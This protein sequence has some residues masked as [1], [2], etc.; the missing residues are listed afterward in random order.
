MRHRV[1]R[2]W[3]SMLLII[4]ISCQPAFAAKKSS[5]VKVKVTLVSVELVENNHVG[6]EWATEAT[7]NG[8][9]LEDG[10]SEKFTLKAGGT[11]KLKAVAEEQDKIP[12][13]GKSEKSIKA[14]SISGAKKYEL[15]VKVVENRG[16]YS[17]K[18][19]HWKFTFK[20][21]KA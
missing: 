1:I 18:T 13:V 3:M 14:S 21:E 19:A 11:L 17:G 16:R 15:K 8:K 6:N 5:D 2:V 10:D 9:I 12:D 4:A 20:V 7:V